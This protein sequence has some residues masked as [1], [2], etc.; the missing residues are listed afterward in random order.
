MPGRLT[1]DEYAK[2][3]GKNAG[4]QLAEERRQ[5]TTRNDQ[6]LKLATRMV[7]TGKGSSSAKSAV[8]R[9][10]S[11]HPVFRG[12]GMSVS[13]VGN[14]W[15]PKKNDD[16]DGSL[17]QEPKKPTSKPSKQIKPKGFPSN[18]N[19]DKYQDDDRD[20]FIHGSGSKRPGGQPKRG[21]YGKHW[22]HPD[23]GVQ[24]GSNFDGYHTPKNKKPRS[25]YRE[26]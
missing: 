8:G 5:R 14:G 9:L 7:N 4:K 16:F 10:I 6:L 19:P 17:F 22:S 3:H 24:D 26:A 11:S 21:K 25:I 2:K 15:K 20:P 12:G 23:N 18:P 13:S 1:S